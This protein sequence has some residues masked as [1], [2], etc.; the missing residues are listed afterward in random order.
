MPKKNARPGEQAI[1]LLAELQRRRQARKYLE[2]KPY[3]TQRAAMECAR[4][5]SVM[6]GGNQTGKSVSLLHLDAWDLTGN[7]PDWF[8][9]PRFNRPIDMW[10]VGDKNETVRDSLQKV[11]FGPDPNKPGE[12]GLIGPHLIVGK[13]TFRHNIAGAFDTIRI[14]H[15]SG[16]TSLITFKSYAQGREALQAWTGDVVHVDEAPPKDCWDELLMRL[17]ARKGRMRMS[18]TPMHG[19]DE[20]V[21]A[22]MAEDNPDVGCFFLSAREAKHLGDDHIKKW[23]RI[24]ANDPQALAARIDGRPTQ[25]HGTVFKGVD[26]EA[27][28]CPELDWPEEWWELGGLDPGWTHPTAMGYALY[29]RNHDTI[30][31][32]RDYLEAGREYWVHARVMRTWGC[33]FVSDPA[34]D[35]TEKSRG[36]T[37]YKLVLGELQPDWEYVPPEDRLLIKADNSRD[38]GNEEVLKRLQSGRLVISENCPRSLEQLK[39]YRYMDNGKIYKVDDDLC[40]VIRYI[41]MSVKHFKPRGGPRQWW[42]NLAQSPRDAKCA[43]GY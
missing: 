41:C 29:D 20:V 14:K 38:A 5:I 4:D 2:F 11:L 17:V 42:R 16:G 31:I 18:F 15:I 40:D 8:N 3:A 22:V 35:Q 36:E 30:F 34:A 7:Y 12:G 39:K 32:V 23:E 24:Y 1:E 33:T 13:P 25:R 19:W 6:M 27:V 21:E 26:W 43:R 28:K 9:G 37:F 10:I